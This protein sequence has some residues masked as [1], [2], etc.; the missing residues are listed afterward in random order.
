MA[1]PTRITVGELDTNCYLV[2][3]PQGILVIDPGA[4]ADT[5]LAALSHHGRQAVRAIL[6]TH[7]HFDH[8]G[9]ANALATALAVPVFA[10]AADEALLDGRLAIFGLRT[11]PIQATLFRDD[12]LPVD[13]GVE[14]ILTPGHTPGSVVYVTAG[15]AFVG[16]TLFAGSVGRTDLPGGDEDV[17]IESLRVLLRRLDHHLPLY[18]GHGPPTSL[19]QE[20]R[21]NP[22]VQ[23]AAEGL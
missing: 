11:P 10:S 17:L 12:Q 22:W 23:E 4:E 13:L 2:D 14:I 16:D 5:I 18:P 6:L 15:A 20:L 1:G 8:T 21:A 3:T 9:A 19:A 7:G